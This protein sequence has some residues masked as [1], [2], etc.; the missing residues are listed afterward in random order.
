MNLI[1]A[2]EAYRVVERS[3]FAASGVRLTKLP[4]PPHFV[5]VACVVQDHNVKHGATIYRRKGCTDEI[6]TTRG[7]R[8]RQVELGP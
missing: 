8:C 3:V 2:H 4:Q 1:H 6:G 7:V 5:R